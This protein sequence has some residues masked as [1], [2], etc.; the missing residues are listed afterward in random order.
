MQK[1]RVTKTRKSNRKNFEII[2]VGDHKSLCFWSGSRENQLLVYIGSTGEARAKECE[3]NLHMWRDCLKE[4]Q[5][6][7]YLGCCVNFS[8]RFHDDLKT[9]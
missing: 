8:Q 9:I 1:A 6:E 3:K 4:I 5:S 7:V 2:C